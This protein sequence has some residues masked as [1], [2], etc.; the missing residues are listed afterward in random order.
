MII[1][2]SR[3]QLTDAGLVGPGAVAYTQQGLRRE[4]GLCKQGKKHTCAHAG[5]GVFVPHAL[6]YRARS[7]HAL[8]YHARSTMPVVTIRGTAPLPPH[9]PYQYHEQSHYCRFMI[10]H[11]LGRMDPYCRHMI[12]HS[13]GRMDI[14]YCSTTFPFT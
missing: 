5:Y 4:L 12:G 7:Y 13:L 14:F 11:C 2:V 3:Q 9:V 6:S 10:R 8:S 1:M